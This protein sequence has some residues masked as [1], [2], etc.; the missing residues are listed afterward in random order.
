MAE[1]EKM[2]IRSWVVLGFFVF[3]VSACND[4]G[5]ITPPPNPQNVY[6]WIDAPLDYPLPRMWRKPLFEGIRV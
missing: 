2:R 4:S 6:I 5:D 3:L 1:E